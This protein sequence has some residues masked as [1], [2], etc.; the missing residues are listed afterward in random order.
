MR[1]WI[2]YIACAC[3][4]CAAVEAR[5]QYDPSFTHYWMME[6]EYNPAAAGSTEYMRIVGTYSAQMSGYDDA[7]KTMYFGADLPAF[8]LN[9][10]HGLGALFMNDEL[11]LFSHKR[12]AI[13]YAY[14]F[15]LFGGVLGAGA[16]CDLVNESFNGSGVD[17]ETSGDPA[18]ATSDV[19]GSKIDAAFGLYYQHKNWNLGLSAQH[20]TAP[21][22]TM[23]ETNQIKIDRT[24]YLTAG[25]NI[26]LRNPFLS[27]R[28]SVFA[29]YDGSEYKA[30]VS[31]RLQYDNDGKML[32]GGASYSP[33]TSVA[34]FVGGKFHGVVLSYSY[35]AYTNGVGLEHG[36]HELILSYEWKLDLFKKGKNLHKSVRLL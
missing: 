8:F 24:Y 35:E 18:F 26:Q 5:A 7:P 25:Y 32:F 17:T 21:T 3:A 30:D 28:P 29:M 15:K 27:I 1:K 10:H 2:R 16:Q 12:F 13:Q 19:N 4:V 9:P 31:A 6:P 14:R 23:G 34:L 20:L 36:A 11:G 22:V 33:E